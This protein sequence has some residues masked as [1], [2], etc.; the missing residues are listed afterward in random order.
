MVDALDASTAS[1]LGA[2]RA[3]LCVVWVKYIDL[4]S[5][6]TRCAPARP[7]ACTWLESRA[8]GCAWVPYLDLASLGSCA[9]CSVWVKYLDLVS[10]GSCAMCSVWVKY[11]DL[12][13]LHP[14][15]G[16]TNHTL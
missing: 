7:V 1:D 8:I 16:Q 3:C 13:S 6:W 10:L 9:M 12:V 15:E 4:V 2:A 5:L 11:I 14:G